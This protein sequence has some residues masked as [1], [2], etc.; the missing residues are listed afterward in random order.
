MSTPPDAEALEIQQSKAAA[1]AVANNIL[2]QPA[3]PWQQQPQHHASQQQQLPLAAASI[4]N[5]SSGIL[6]SSASTGSSSAATDLKWQDVWRLLSPDWP[7]LLG[8]AACAVV[9]VLCNVFVA[10]TMGRVVD[11]IGRGTL[12]TPREL[13]MA[14]GKLGAVYVGS[15]VALAAQVALSQGIS[16]SLA[17]RLRS[18]LFM[19]LLGREAL[20]FD[21]VKTGQMTSWLGQDVEVLQTTVAKLLGARGVR[22]AFET[23]AIIAML[24]HLSPLLATTLL[25]AAP[26]LTPVTVRLTNQIGAASKQSQAAADEVSGTA[27]EFVENIKIVK[28]FGAEGRE[29][30]RFQGLVDKAH[31]LAKRV[32][33][34]QGLLDVSS[35]LRNTLCV[36]TTL[37][38]GTWLAIQGKV[39]TGLCYAFFIFAFS[40]AFSLGNLAN[41]S[42]DVAKAA[43]AV[44]RAL[45]A[46]RQAEGEGTGTAGAAPGTALT[47]SSGG[48][49][50]GISSS[51]GVGEERAQ[52]TS[53][54]GGSDSPLGQIP[55]EQFQ[56][57]VEFRNVSFRHPGW[58]GWT[59]VDIS[60]QV[61][62]N[63]T[64]ALVGPSGGGKS[65]LAS[66]LMGLYEVERGSILVDGVP[67]QQLDLHWWRRQLGVVMQDAGLLTGTVREIIAYGQP[68]A[69]AGEVE[70]AAR[71]AQ[72]HDFIQDLPQ[73]YDTVIGPRGVEVSGGQQQRL[74]IARAL[75]VRPRVLL[76]DEATS[77]LDVETEASVAQALQQAAEGTTTLIIAHRLSTVRRAD[78][79]VVVAAGRI[80]EQGTH[81][82]LMQHKGIY[83]RLVRKAQRR[84]LDSWDG[85]EQSSASDASDASDEEVIGGEASAPQPALSSR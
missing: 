78:R 22:S 31:G 60:F 76:F 18:Q 38:L 79:I 66:L 4:T 85:E 36:L 41:T 73:G 80:A 62:P 44:A 13:G 53:S 84:G 32:V 75:L 5:S 23:L 61:P 64:V 68:D 83:Y 19:R 12:T 56:G 24:Y 6:S 33:W 69:T 55:P 67:L 30:G 25:V 10:P 27:D 21:R 29:L 7:L 51:N 20:F 16:E 42:G 57:A 63:A 35:R 1:E 11:V 14:V 50:S 2:P 39:T 74:A 17:A 43:G 49:S 65:T 72:A 15:N 26:L 34:L 9:S 54:S 48:G 82:E 52:S 40:F 58:E 81:G 71:A 77:A 8:C 45:A 46:M 47:S 70:A 28:L 3:N 59:L 37:G